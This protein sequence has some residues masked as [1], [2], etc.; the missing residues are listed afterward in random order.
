MTGMTTTTGESVKLGDRVRYDVPTPR[1]ARA[2]LTRSEAGN[3]QDVHLFYQLDAAYRRTAADDAISVLVLAAE[4]DDFSL[5][6]DVEALFTT[7]GREQVTLE[8]GF[9]RSGVEGDMAW[10]TEVFLE[11]HW[12]RRN[13]PKPVVAAVQVSS[14]ST[15]RPTPPRNDCPTPPEGR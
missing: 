5:G 1:V 2:T 7:D 13:F 8:G 15:S 12:R 14:G 11:L 6:H 9:S 10:E 4:G 3:L